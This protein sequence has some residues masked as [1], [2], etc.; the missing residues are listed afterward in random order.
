M[1]C[2]TVRSLL[3]PYLDGELAPAQVAW[4][5]A[6][7]EICDDCNAAAAQLSAQGQLLAALPPPP[8]PSKLAEDLWSRMDAR[9]G[10]ELDAMEQAAPSTPPAPKRRVPRP[11]IIRLSRRAIAVYAAVLGLAVAFGLWRHDAAATAEARVQDLRVQL[12]RA[13]RLRADPRPMP[14][15][16]SSDYQTAS[17]VRGRGHL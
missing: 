16:A 17:Y 11:E 8:L 4:I 9:L 3:V 12:E 14:V 2:A 6:H 10:A 15:R 7:R 5:D 1:D 13:E